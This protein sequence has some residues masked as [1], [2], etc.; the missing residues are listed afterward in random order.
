M[1]EIKD[2]IIL[3]LELEDITKD[4]FKDILELT[5]NE[6]VMKYIGN[7]KVWDNKNVNNFIKYCLDD[8]KNKDNKRENYYY[9]IISHENDNEIDK[10]NKTLNKIFIGIIGFHKFY[11]SSLFTTRNEFYLTVYMNPKEQGKGYYNR[12][13]EL[14]IKKMRKHQPGKTKLYLLVRQSNEKMNLISKKKYNFINEVKI[15]QEKLN[16]YYIDLGL[17]L[18]FKYNSR[19]RSSVKKTKI[20]K[21]I[22]GNRK[23]TKRITKKNENK[24]KKH[25]HYYL[26]FAKNVDENRIDKIFQKRG[27]WVKYNVNRDK[28]KQIDY[29]Y[30]DHQDNI[31]N[32]KVHSYKS[33][34]KNFIDEKKHVVGHKDE[35]YKNLGDTLK[36]NPSL[37][38]KNYLLEQ[39]N[40]DWQEIYN[41]NKV[42][43]TVEYIKGLFNKNVGKVWIY[44]PVAGFAGQ[45]IEIFKSFDEFYQ[46]ITQF[47]EKQKDIWVDPKFKEKAR[48]KV[49][50]NWV[51][52]E[53]IN[54]PILF[55]NKKFHIR[56]IFL[57]QKKGN[58]KI[59]YLLNR[60][61]VAHA[62]EDYKF[63][64]FG[65]KNIHD[66]HFG[67]T[68]GRLYFQDDF[69]KLKILTKKEIEHIEEQVKDLGKYVFDL[70]NSRCYSE[71]KE[72]YETF[73][74]DIMID[75]TLTIKVL[76]VQITN[77]SYGF[78]DN[79]KLPGY[80]NIFEYI[81]ENAVETVVDPYFPPK[82]P[83]KK[84]GAFQEIYNKNIS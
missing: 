43:K 82:N 71:N 39:H 5:S 23:I 42:E 25:K 29:I 35:L 16:H 53:Y 32:K 64:D 75:S 70:I 59:G 36:K 2:K 69:L 17:K 81:L 7:S 74:M 20:T 57:Y 84:I 33:F 12:A 14:L 37:S 55:E 31:Y 65:N 34:L 1:K 21:R 56:P 40:F 11:N 24:E 38:L 76:E 48:L 51:L 73:G 45:M 66:S 13:I 67:K 47:I 8:E 83:I 41:Q 80:S 10:T 46:Y 26:A 54:Q 28:G 60:I 61:L 62:K 72:C 79:D 19:I 4:D 77:I 27:N 22:T 63:D 68:S 3:N 9:K 30:I 49:Q 50:S 6:D 58:R 15:N 52:Q 44:K 78:F 18:N